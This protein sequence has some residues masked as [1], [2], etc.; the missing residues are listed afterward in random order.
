MIE[1]G[2][3]TLVD[4]SGRKEEKAKGKEQMC[5]EAPESRIQNCSDANFCCKDTER[6]IPVEYE[7]DGEIDDV[8][9]EVDDVV[10]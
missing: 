4:S 10:R 5:L 1:L 6:H 3:V 8:D 9:D 7:V 2:N